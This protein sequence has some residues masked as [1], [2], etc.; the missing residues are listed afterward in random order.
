MQKTE[1][2]GGYMKKLIIFNKPFGVLSQFSTS[3]GA[4]TLADYIPIKDVYP[5]GRLDKDSEGLL[6]LTNDGNLQHKISHPK[7]KM[8]KH[9]WVQV[10]H[11]PCESDL[12]KIR[13]GIKISKHQCLPAA[14]KHIQPPSVWQRTSPIRE[15]K[16]I[17]TCWLDIKIKEG[18][19]RQ[20]RRMTA[21]MGFPTLRLIRHKIGPWSLEQ[22]QPGA[23]KI[24]SI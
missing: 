1:R 23:Y 20:V 10:E 16:S 19:N 12:D 21:A 5:A 13:N 22:L 9:Y 15:R 17:P 14:I 4:K 8:S 3:D 6:L 2:I 11:I 18:K 24:L 7:Q